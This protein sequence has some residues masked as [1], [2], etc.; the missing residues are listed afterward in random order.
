VILGTR[1]RA[2][3]EEALIRATAELLSN[4]GPNA[5]SVRAIAERAGV[6]HGLVHHYFGSK[7][8]LIRAV[9]EVLASDSD[10]AIREHGLDAV[11]D[12]ADDRVRMHVRVLVRVLLDDAVPPDYQAPFP[13]VDHLRRLS[14]EAP[15]VDEET[16]R[17]RAMQTAALTAG[18]IIFEPWLLGSGDPQDVARARADLQ[19]AITRLAAG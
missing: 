17:Y 11:L 9:L 18:W 6:N 8:G 14:S 19:P 4:V 10:A 3:S 12:P 5:V 13:I 7:G 1:G 15:S 2:S 16:A